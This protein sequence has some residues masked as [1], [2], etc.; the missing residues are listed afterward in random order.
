MHGQTNRINQ[1]VLMISSSQVLRWAHKIQSYAVII[2]E[3]QA[4]MNPKMK[5][6][7]RIVIQLSADLA[8]GWTNVS[9]LTNLIFLFHL[10]N[11]G[12]IYQRSLFYIPFYPLFNS[13][14]NHHSRQIVRTDIKSENLLVDKNHTLKIT[15]FGLSRFQALNPNHL[16]DLIR[17]ST[18][19]LLQLRSISYITTYLFFLMSLYKEKRVKKI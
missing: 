10:Q 8:R 17:N 3:N 19:K 11:A 1:F 4:T 9:F 15:Y 5:L 6:P 18:S 14:S 12:V 16:T 13:L 7:F 2:L